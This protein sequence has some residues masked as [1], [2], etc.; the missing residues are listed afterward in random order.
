M[1]QLKLR[2]DLKKESTIAYS[3]FVTF[4]L[5]YALGPAVGLLS[6]SFDSFEIENKNEV[7][8]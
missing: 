3:G 2:Q 4:S 5:G 8:Q 7:E 1:K 6:F